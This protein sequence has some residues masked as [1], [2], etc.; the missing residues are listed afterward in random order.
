MY[1]YILAMNLYVC[2]HIYIESKDGGRYLISPGLTAH[3]VEKTNCKNKYGTVLHSRMQA[4]VYIICV[5]PFQLA[6]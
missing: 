4:A 1:V 6:I 3:R 5:A 2:L